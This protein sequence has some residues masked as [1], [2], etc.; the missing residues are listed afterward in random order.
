MDYLNR[1]QPGDC[2]VHRLLEAR[3]AESP[4]EAFF[5]FEGRTLTLGECNRM[6]NRV[7]RNL[8]AAGVGPGSHVAVLM[9]STPDYMVLWFAL[10]KLGAVEAPINTAYRGDLLQHVLKTCKATACVLEDRFVDTVGEASSG[11]APFSQV[12]VRGDEA[13]G[14]TAAMRFD[15]LLKD[16]DESNGDW[17]ARHDDVTC[18][19]FTSGTTGPSKGV[20]L[21][22]HYLTAYGLMYAEVNGLRGDD[23]VMNFLPFFHIAAKFLSIAVLACGGRMLLQRRLSISTFW[24][25]VRTHGVTNFLGVGGI[26][27]MLISRPESPDDGNTT[28][29]TI[30]AVPDPADIHEELERRFKC[31]IT[32][33]FG[34]TEAGLPL[35]RGV[36]D[37]YRPTSCGR[38]SP[39]YEV[40]VVDEDDNPAPVGVSGEIVVRPKRPYLVG[41]GYIGMPER[42]VKAWRNLWLHTGDRGHVDAEGF[43]YFD[44]RLSDSIRRRGE[45]ISSYEVEAI[46]SKH[47]G[48]SEVVAVAA[49]SE[50]GEDEVRVLVIARQGHSLQAQDVLQ[51]CCRHMPYFMVPRFIDV[52]DD[53]PRTATAKVEKYKIRAA[54]CGVG[55][56]DREAHG[57]KVTREGLYAH[58]GA[59]VIRF[60]GC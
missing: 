60:G 46:V 36:N 24:Q 6:A 54:G 47:P 32:T 23:V 18:I 37:P 30:Y 2:I 13:S 9:D 27:N 57:W 11:F 22:Q 25:E 28:I 4:H 31:R 10:S 45:N 58:D 50:V 17:P 26:C 40:Q 5:T 43:F 7:A 52:V 55:T 12:F 8:Q 16:N 20:L 59:V 38:Q 49:A 35:F 14:G 19:I 51:H 34:S 33:V 1:I 56:W 21:S 44:D 42:T 3:A 53:L 29:R 15:S 41:S 48:V 39:Y